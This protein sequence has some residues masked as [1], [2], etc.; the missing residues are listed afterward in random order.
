MTTSDDLLR[1]TLPMLVRLGDFIGNGDLDPTREGSLGSRCDLILDIKRHL[2]PALVGEERSAADDELAR[3]EAEFAANGG[4]G[5]DLAERIDAL[6]ANTPPTPAT[7]YPVSS[8]FA[9]EEI[10]AALRTLAELYANSDDDTGDYLSGRQQEIAEAVM[11]AVAGDD[12]K[13]V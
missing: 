5:V 10:E 6:R 3:L 7:P 9:A 1:R 12:E 13:W 11:H 8:R 2:D 4:R